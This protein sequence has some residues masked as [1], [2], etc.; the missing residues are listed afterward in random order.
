MDKR[1]SEQPGQDQNKVSIYR[2]MLRGSS[3]AVA[4]TWTLRGIGLIN[5]VIL[6]RLLAPEDFGLVTMASLAFGFLGT[7]A[8]L[9]TGTLL[10]RQP[11]ATREHCDTAWT[12]SLLRG[13]LVAV[14][15]VAT[16]P[17]IAAYFRE[18]RVVPLVYVVAFNSVLL[19]ALNVGLVL[20]RKE[21]DFGREFRYTVFSRLFTFVVTVAL[22]LALRSYW[23]LAIGTTIGL[24][25]EC[26][27]SYRMHPYRPRLSLAKAG[28]YVRF[29]L[30]LVPLNICFYL[31]AKVDSFVVGRIAPA[32]TLG[33][34]NVAADLSTMLTSDLTTQIG[35]ALYPSYAKLTDDYA[36]LRDA[37]LKSLSGLVIVNVAF[38]LGLFA[39]SADF[40]AV[41]LGP[42]WRDTVPLIEWLAICG[43]LRAIMHNLTS[44]I[45]VVAG[46]ERVAAFLMFVRFAVLAAFAIAG[47][48][49][50]GVQGVAIGVTLGTAVILPIGAITLVRLLG[51]RFASLLGVFWRPLLAGI[52]MVVAVRVL[53]ATS[54][55]EPLLT[56]ALDVLIGAVVFLSILVALWRLSGRPDGAE[57]MAID[58]VSRMR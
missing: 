51:F 8:N 13:V 49:F 52:V 7:F 5:T 30:T 20:M 28:E 38:G 19:G 6:A 57:K 16:A 27:L 22:A 1:P 36:K 46:R 23:A 53:H 32:P 33:I 34:Y 18:E 10:I 50:W 4:L 58:V 45:L 44:G 24:A 39:V 9:G 21:L 29:S 26:W 35:R 17:L 41:V 11:E 42:K 14:T 48:R 40:V 31:A 15:L 56:L 12:I 43:M 3:W 55:E 25:F 37:Y 47:G 54:L 2:H